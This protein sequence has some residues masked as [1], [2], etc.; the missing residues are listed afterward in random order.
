M[1]EK[2]VNVSDFVI[3]FKNYFLKLFQNHLT[4]QQTAFIYIYIHRRI[5][6]NK[7]VIYFRIIS[8]CK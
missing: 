2:L 7:C 1:L 8:F 4:D 5:L 3:E 6:K